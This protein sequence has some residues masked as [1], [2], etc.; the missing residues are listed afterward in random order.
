MLGPMYTFTSACK[1]LITGERPTVVYMVTNDTDFVSEMMPVLQGTP[2]IVATSS[3]QLADHLK[4]RNILHNRV[5]IPPDLGLGVLDLARE[6][7]ERAF[8]EGFVSVNDRVMCIVRSGIDSTFVYDFKDIG[9]AHL[10]A[11]VG[12]R[13]SVE[14][15]ELVIQLAFQIAREGRE[16]QPMGALLV[17]GDTEAV[18]RHSRPRIINPFQ[19]HPEKEREIWVMGNWNTIKAYAQMDGATLI[20][21]KGVARAAGRYMSY[22]WDVYLSGG[23]GGRHIAAASITKLTNA[24]AVVVSSTSVVRV[25][26]DGTEIY[27]ASAY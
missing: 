25:F 27:K 21:E 10:K 7:V 24:I 6:L 13:V 14:L 20:D 2:L 19:G 18:L 11:D 3:Q 4:E 12:K 22:T 26:K 17:V 16:G 15:M 5:S 23:L 8:L 9:L 1:L